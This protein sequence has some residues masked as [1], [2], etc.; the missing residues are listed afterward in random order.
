MN[1]Y[2]KK[3]KYM[4]CCNV[5]KVYDLRNSLPL[6]NPPK[7]F[8]F[9]L[10]TKGKYDVLCTFFKTEYFKNIKDIFNMMLWMRFTRVWYRVSILHLSVPYININVLNTS[11]CYF[12]TLGCCPFLEFSFGLGYFGPG[13]FFFR[14][15]LFRIGS[16]FFGSGLRRFLDFG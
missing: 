3:P 16:M 2:R 7:W 9:S 14:V 8:Q 11:F 12:I 15:G 5:T 1:I 6:E 4:W 13:P 10:C